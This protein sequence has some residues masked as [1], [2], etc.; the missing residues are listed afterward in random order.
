[1]HESAA[2]G[3]GLHNSLKIIIFSPREDGFR[4][5]HPKARGI[6]VNEKSD[7]NERLNFVFTIS[8]NGH[9]VSLTHL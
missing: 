9:D 5:A 4:P 2:Q 1:M 3:G 6:L 7:K 8:A